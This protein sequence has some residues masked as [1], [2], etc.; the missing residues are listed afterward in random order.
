MKEIILLTSTLITALL[1]SCFFI[2]LIW[3]CLAAVK[4]RKIRKI[5]RIAPVFDSQ[6]ETSIV[7]KPD[8]K[9]K[10]GKVKISKSM[11]KFPLT[12]RDN[13]ND[14]IKEQVEHQQMN[15]I[16]QNFELDVINSKNGLEE[17]INLQDN[18]QYF[19]EKEN[20]R[21]FTENELET[22]IDE[23]KEVFNAYEKTNKSFFDD[24]IV[25]LEDVKQEQSINND[26]EANLEEIIEIKRKKSASTETDDHFVKFFPC[27]KWDKEVQFTSQ[28][29]VQNKNFILKKKILKPELSQKRVKVNLNPIRNNVRSSFNRIKGIDPKNFVEKNIVIVTESSALRKSTSSRLG[30]DKQLTSKP[31]ETKFKKVKL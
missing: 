21:I 15:P 23:P 24:E 10:T 3:F 8:C 29:L 5:A 7:S 30:N 20:N 13:S 4:K 16:I 28:E 19:E 11:D 9:T 12:N 17:R 26:E 14:R 31:E 2:F 1:G 27:I 18:F 6:S 25:P 22:V